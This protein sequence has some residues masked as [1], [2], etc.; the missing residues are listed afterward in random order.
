MIAIKNY[1]TQD[2]HPGY[3]LDEVENAFKSIEKY[4]QVYSSIFLMASLAE[5]IKLLINRAYFNPK[6]KTLKLIL[7]NNAYDTEDRLNNYKR[8]LE[9]LDEYP[10]WREKFEGDISKLFAFTNTI[11]D[12]PEIYELVDQQKI[13]K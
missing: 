3:Y 7:S 9:D 4:C 5:E 12:T 1:Y 6:K 11:F 2:L 8:I 13:F 10:L